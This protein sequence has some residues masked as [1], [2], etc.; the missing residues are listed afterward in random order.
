MLKHGESGYR[1]L[2]SGIMKTTKVLQEGI[3]AIEGLSLLGN[4]DMSV[5]AIKSTDRK[6]SIYAVADVLE[7][8]GWF[9]DR[10]STPE[11]I[12][13]TVTPVHSGKEEVFLSD[14]KSAVQ[15]VRENP[16]RSLSGKAAQYGLI[17]HLPARGFVKNEVRKTMAG[18]IQGNSTVQKELPVWQK[19]LLKLIR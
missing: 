17:S 1:K 18:I 9:I 14:L 19:W 7:E 15:T 2:F 4:P 10:Q 12:H 16:N 6:L 5:F 8:K 3:C 13:F 11:S